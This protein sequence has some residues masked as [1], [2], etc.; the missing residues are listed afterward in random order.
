MAWSDYNFHF[1][2]TV[3]KQ[4]VDELKRLETTPLNEDSLAE[5]EAFQDKINSSQGIYLLHLRNEPVYLGKAGNVRERLAQHLNKLT[6]R[7]HGS[8]RLDLCEIG[9][10]VLLL[11]QSMSTAANEDILIAFFQNDHKGLWNNKGFGPKDPGKHRDTTKPSYFDKEYPINRAF[12][13]TGLKNNVT[14]GDLFKVMKKTLPFVFRY[15]K[16]PKAIA[17]TLLDLTEVKREAEILLRFAMNQFPAGWHAAMVGFGMVVYKGRKAYWHTAEV[18]VSTGS[19]PPLPPITEDD[20]EEDI[21]G[22]DFQ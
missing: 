6:G 8:E 14:I 2:N 10:K 18:V 9:F 4:L 11:D 3:S 20:A 13:V 19:L 5:L 15:Q 1:L 7:I 12:P 16:L 21:S 22:D 17:D